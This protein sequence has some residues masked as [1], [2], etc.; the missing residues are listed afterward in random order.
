MQEL[1]SPPAVFL[2]LGIHRILCQQ[3]S[4]WKQL[5][6][7]KGVRFDPHKP[8]DLGM[9]TPPPQRFLKPQGVNDP[10]LTLILEIQPPTDH[11]SVEKGQSLGEIAW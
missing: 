5:E 8:H 6:T 10:F 1:Q 4:E 3:Q 9:M 2:F 11:C 7:G